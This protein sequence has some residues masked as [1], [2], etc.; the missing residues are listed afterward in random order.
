MSRELS[1][2]RL[3]AMRFLYLLTGIVLGI[4]VWPTMFNRVKPWD[5]VHGI[6]F[7]FWGALSILMLLGVRFP[8]RMLPLLL[9][10][11]FYKLIWLIGVGYPLSSAHQLGPVASD[12]LKA[13]GIG[14]VLDLIVIPWP[15]VFE[16]YVKAIFK[17]QGK[18]ES[19]SPYRSS[20]SK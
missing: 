18:Q 14:A 13:C 17:R 20:I 15:Y 1:T 19:L 8:I 5:P 16:N 12:L 2:I 9:L 6:A 3:Y 10:Q 7:S 11:L 4:D